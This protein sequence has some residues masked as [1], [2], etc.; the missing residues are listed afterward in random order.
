MPLTDC[1]SADSVHP[2]GASDSDE[3][4]LPGLDLIPALGWS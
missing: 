4:G 3:P 1:T 2:V